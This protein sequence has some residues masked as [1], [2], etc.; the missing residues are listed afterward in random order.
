MSG[1][2]QGIMLTNDEWEGLSDID[3][4]V[5]DYDGAISFGRSQVRS[6]RLSGVKLA[7][8]CMLFNDN[9]DSY[10]VGGRAEDTAFSELGIPI[11]TFTKYSQAYKWVINNQQQSYKIRRLMHGKPIGGSILLI[12]AAREGELSKDDWEELAHAPD[13]KSM[14]AVRDRVR[15]I[16]TSGYNRVNIECMPD[17]ILRG[18]QTFKG[19]DGKEDETVFVPLGYLVQ[20]DDFDEDPRKSHIQEVGI[21]RL[22]GVGVIRR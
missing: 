12:A 16:V 9:W 11:V 15:G 4:A 3:E 7:R 13:V 18:S 21:E 1:L 6:Q 14:R 5:K 22:M 2:D 17:G 19:E 10:G 20:P 8:F